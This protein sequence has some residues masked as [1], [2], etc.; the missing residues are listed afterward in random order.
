MSQSRDFDRSE[1]LRMELAYVLPLHGLDR[2]LV[3]ESIRLRHSAPRPLLTWSH[4]TQ[5]VSA[6]PLNVDSQL[7]ATV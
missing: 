4:S 2:A 1:G 7:A 6:S 5:K 3:R